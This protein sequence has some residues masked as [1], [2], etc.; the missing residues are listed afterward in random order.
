MAV[1]GATASVAVPQSAASGTDAATCTAVNSFGQ[2]QGSTQITIQAAAT[3][4]T[5]NSVSATT[6][7]LF[8][9]TPGL[10]IPA[11]VLGSGF[12]IGGTLITTY[13]DGFV[14]KTPLTATNTPSSSQIN[15][16]VSTGAAN[17]GVITF[18]V[19]N[20][21]VGGGLSNIFSTL[22]LPNVKTTAFTLTSAGDPVDIVVSDYYTQTITGYKVSDG[23]RDPNLNIL[24]FGTLAWSSGANSLLEGNGPYIL[25]IPSK[26]GG[27]QITSTPSGVATSGNL[28]FF[29]EFSGQVGCFVPNIGGLSDN[30]YV[31]VGNP[32]DQ[33]WLVS[34]VS[35]TL[36]NGKLVAVVYDANSAVATFVDMS[37]CTS[38]SIL[39]TV[40]LPFTKA[41][42][43]G[44][45]VGFWEFVSSSGGSLAALSTVDGL[46]VGIDP[47]TMAIT[48][49]TKKLS[50]IPNAIALNSDGTA[51]VAS[52]TFTSPQQTTF[53]NVNLQGEIT[54][55]D[56]TFEHPCDWIDLTPDGS[57]IYCEYDGLDT[58]IAN[59]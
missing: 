36:P 44:Y 51:V 5:I 32:A 18:Q 34:I 13:M 47:S 53:V 30:N 56:A 41:L 7:G 21:A 14:T 26:T 17:P 29:A 24:G 3:T 49:T 28:G 27:T 33:K 52:W 10:T 57:T 20:T 16:S 2:A 25:T 8:S 6:G 40:T 42:S 45:A 12:Q 43:L 23:S 55:M 54:S 22:L 50:G 31:T 39:G 59:Q 4:L 58:P 37:S 38:P 48:Y 19:D 1:S 9:G 15:A 11:A 35:L 46:V